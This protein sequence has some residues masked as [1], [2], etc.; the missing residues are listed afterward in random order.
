MIVRIWRT[1]IDE[2]RAGEYRDF[3][4]SRS[5]P[6]FRAQP[7]FAGVLFA[8]RQA[9]RAVITLWHDLASVE[10]LDHSQTYKTTVEEIEVTGFLHGQSTVEVLEVEDILVEANAMRSE[11]P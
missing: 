8:T 3:A 1:Q 11:T 7:G 10:A 4:R 5:L 6:M 9:E 2:T